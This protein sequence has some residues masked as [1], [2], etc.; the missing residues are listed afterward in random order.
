[1]WEGATGER[2]RCGHK[3]NVR[4]PHKEREFGVIAQTD[5]LF[6]I[7]ETK[8]TPPEDDA[9]GFVN[10]LASLADYSPRAPR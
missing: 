9:R 6:F 5:R 7:D 1:M 4:D 2:S 8:T 10:L 3:W